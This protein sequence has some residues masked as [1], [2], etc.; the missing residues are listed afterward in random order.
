[1]GEHSKLHNYVL[2]DRRGSQLGRGRRGDTLH[3]SNNF[4]EETGYPRHWDGIFAELGGEGG[5]H[6][7]S[8]R[9][10]NRTHGMN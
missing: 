1:V 9:M 2:A 8:L 7:F 10:Q 6:L 3:T 5:L 4:Q